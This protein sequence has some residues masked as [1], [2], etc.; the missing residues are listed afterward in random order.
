MLIKGMRVWEL[1]L[2]GIALKCSDS[3]HR[4]KVPLLCPITNKLCIALVA[5][6]GLLECVACHVPV[7]IRI[8]SKSLLTKVARHPI[9]PQMDMFDV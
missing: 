5:L 1:F 6:D 7:K 2:T 3:M 4:I 8:S 9:F